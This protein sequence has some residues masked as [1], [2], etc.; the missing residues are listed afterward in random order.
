MESIFSTNCQIIGIPWRYS[1]EPLGPIGS[2]G[3]WRTPVLFSLLE[4]PPSRPTGQCST[5]LSHGHRG[6]W[7][8]GSFVSWGQKEAPTLLPKWLHIILLECRVMD[9]RAGAKHAFLSRW[10]DV[11][12]CWGLPVSPGPGHGNASG[13][14]HMIAGC[15][16]TDPGDP[17]P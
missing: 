8:T 6:L 15:W 13:T 2:L 14:H 10:E 12:D 9:G 3:K 5:N 1:V 4:W 7:F 17:V 16:S 11:G